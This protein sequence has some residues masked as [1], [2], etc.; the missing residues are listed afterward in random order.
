MR[1]TVNSTNATGRVSRRDSGKNDSFA[2]TALWVEPFD[3]REQAIIW[4]A[5]NCANRIVHRPDHNQMSGMP[6]S[7]F[8]ESVRPVTNIVGCPGAP[9]LAQIVASRI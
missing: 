8:R 2:E 1:L 3:S 5:V 9:N 7:R 6:M 4:K